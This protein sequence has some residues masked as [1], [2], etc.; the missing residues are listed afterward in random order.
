[1][2][3]DAEPNSYKAVMAGL[4]TEQRWSMRA[5][6]MFFALFGA[7]LMFHFPVL[8]YT[9]PTVLFPGI[10]RLGSIRGEQWHGAHYPD[11]YLSDHTPL[12]KLYLIS[13]G[14][15]LVFTV[16]L[17]V[18]SAQMQLMATYWIG[19]LGMCF[20]T[21]FFHVKGV[22]AG[23]AR[24]HDPK[25]VSE[26]EAKK[27]VLIEKPKAM[28]NVKGQTVVFAVLAV[29]A[30][31]SIVSMRPGLEAAQAAA[32]QQAEQQTAQDAMAEGIDTPA[33]VKT[34]A[35]AQAQA[36][37]PQEQPAQEATP[38]QQAATPQAQ[39][40]SAP[41]APVTPEVAAMT[42]ADVAQATHASPSP[43]QLFNVKLIGATIAH[44]ETIAGPAVKVV[45]MANSVESRVYQVNGCTIEIGVG[46]GTITT[47]GVALNPSCSI[48]EASLPSYL[49][50]QHLDFGYLT[51][52][53]LAKLANN[54]PSTLEL[55]CAAQNECG[56]GT[57]PSMRLTIEGS[58]ADGFINAT[59]N[60]PIVTA[61]DTNVLSREMPQEAKKLGVSD[62]ELTSKAYNQDASFLKHI[63]PWLSGVKVTTLMLSE[64]N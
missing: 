43:D 34:P 19:F 45:P 32:D 57:D 56:N 18:L 54:S 2:N 1:V 62:M 50:G 61:A 9:L 37:T 38:V 22:L 12:K 6:G 25:L 36:P 11:G 44:Y 60:G 8:L 52:R 31:V 42:A 55:D 4:T 33:D 15:G 41:T 13:A 35:D 14:L 24:V 21:S 10:A 27:L 7:K 53:G 16:I 48:S 26:D 63:I 20:F 29:F 40:M 46:H 23:W 64:G 59:F 58:Q 39:V 5:Y 47:I 30:L 17:G 51:F 28:R 49:Q 3:T